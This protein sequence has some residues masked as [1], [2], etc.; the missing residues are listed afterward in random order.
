MFFLRSSTGIKYL[1][2]L[3][4]HMQIKMWKNCRVKKQLKYLIKQEMILIISGLLYIYTRFFIFTW[5]VT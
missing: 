3:C 4:E 1:A 2:P 5:N